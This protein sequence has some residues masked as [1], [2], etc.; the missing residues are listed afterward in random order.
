MSLLLDSDG[1]GDDGAIARAV[2]IGDG[3]FNKRTE[4]GGGVRAAE[5][6]TGLAA[7]SGPGVAVGVASIPGSVLRLRLQLRANISDLMVS[8]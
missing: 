5:S 1:D 7:D 3:D 6:W 8:V 4:A 2:G